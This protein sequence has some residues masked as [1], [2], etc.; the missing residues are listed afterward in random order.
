MRKH[1]TAKRHAGGVLVTVGREPAE[2]L[3]EPDEA[4]ALVLEM[5]EALGHSRVLRDY[6]RASMGLPEPDHPNPPGSG[7]SS[8]G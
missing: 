3:L 5:L 1:H 2:V 6:V 4:R 8:T 7:T